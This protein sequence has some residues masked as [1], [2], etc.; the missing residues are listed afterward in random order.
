MNKPLTEQEENVVKDVLRRI[1]N[2]TT[3]YPMF[4]KA[5]NLSEVEFDSIADSVFKKLG[6]GR[7]TVAS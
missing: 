2:D 3:L 1:G 6:N 5:C 7:L 4:A